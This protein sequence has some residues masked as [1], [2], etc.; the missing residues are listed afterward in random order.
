MRVPMHHYYAVQGTYHCL[1]Q[2]M[3]QDRWRIA[4]C[5]AAGMQGRVRTLPLCESSREDVV[6]SIAQFLSPRNPFQARLPGEESTMH[7]CHA[8]RGQLRALAST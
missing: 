3:L 7:A 4:S 8:L 5:R 2:Y 6:Q 1:C